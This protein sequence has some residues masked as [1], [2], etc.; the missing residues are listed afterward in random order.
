MDH[1]AA[2]ISLY[3]VGRTS[4]VIIT[5]VFESY[6]EVPW[7]HNSKE[8]RVGIAYTKL[9]QHYFFLLSLISDQI[10]SLTQKTQWNCWLNAETT[11]FL[12]LSYQCVTLK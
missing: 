11:T 5:P 2:G 12:H 7:R 6:Q 9:Y 10:K 4:V 3:L 8:P 1:T